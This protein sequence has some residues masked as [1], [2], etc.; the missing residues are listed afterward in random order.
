MNEPLL[1]KVGAL[2]QYRHN[3]N[4]DFVFGYD[5]EEA[6]LLVTKLATDNKEMKAFLNHVKRMI[7]RGYVNLGD[8]NHVELYRLLNAKGV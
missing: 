2:R 5:L 6:D 4:D 7:L 8:D 1:V 3:N